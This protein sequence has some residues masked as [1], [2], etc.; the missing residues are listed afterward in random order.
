MKRSLLAF[1][2]FALLGTGCLPRYMVKIEKCPD[3]RTIKPEPGKA[4]LV[5]GR[6]TSFG[7]GNNFEHY[8]GREFIGSTNGYGFFVTIMDTGDQFVTAQSENHNTVYLKALADKTYYLQDGVSFGIMKPHVFLDA[9]PGESLYKSMD[10][11]CNFYALDTKE[12]ADKLDPDEWVSAQEARP[13]AK[14]AGK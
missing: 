11:D 6:T 12:K 1:S 13:G 2:L 7:G 3:L 5:I 9:V 14:P 10:G 8:L 4:A